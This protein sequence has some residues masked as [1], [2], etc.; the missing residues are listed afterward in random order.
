M[1]TSSS[2]YYHFI[3]YHDTPCI[4]IIDRNIGSVPVTRDIDNVVKYI[5]NVN[6]IDYEDACDFLWLYADEDLVWDAYDP[7]T[8]EIIELACYNC[9]DAIVKYYCRRQLEMR[10]LTM[11]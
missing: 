3:D 9:E 2:F 8:E 1:P 5:C 11:A 10:K 7:I 4:A 6:N